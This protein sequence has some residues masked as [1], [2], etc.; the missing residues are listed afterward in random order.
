MY[1]FSG[2]CCKRDDILFAHTRARCRNFAN[3]LLSI[4]APATRAEPG[5]PVQITCSE[6][7]A[8]SVESE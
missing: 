2:E 8:V 5:D 1:G 6:A 4:D 7:V 3:L